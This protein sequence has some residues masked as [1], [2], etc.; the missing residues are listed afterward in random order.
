[1]GWDLSRASLICNIELEKDPAK[2][3]VCLKEDC[4]GDLGE[5]IPKG[6][7]LVV[8]FGFILLFVGDYDILPREETT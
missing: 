4:T 1:M 2:T 6:F 7:L 3:S 5:G 8:P